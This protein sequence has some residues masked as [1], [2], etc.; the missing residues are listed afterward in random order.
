M[1][2]DQSTPL[3]MQ[4]QAIKSEYQDSLVLFQVG[5]FYELFYDDAK[6]AASFL[7]IA[8]TK[9][10]KSQGM[11]IPL[12]GV[13]LH[14]INH[15]ITKLVKGGFKVALC[16]Q[17]ESPKPGTV[18][19]R[20]VTRV[21]TPG[22]LT[23]EI[24]LDSKS[25]SYLCA[26][27]NSGFIMAEILTARLSI[28]SLD[29]NNERCIENELARFYPDEIILKQ[30]DSLANILKK[31]GYPVTELAMDFSFIVN[32]CTAWM[33]T[34][35]KNDDF[36]KIAHNNDIKIAFTYFYAYIKKTQ[37]KIL[38]MMVSV[39]WY[40]PEEFLEIDRMTQKNLELVLN[41]YDGTSKGT[42]FSVIDQS[43][44]AMGSR[45]I[46]QW[47][48]RPLM[49]QQAIEQRQSVIEL[50][51]NNVR[52]HHR[53]QELL[54]SIGDIERTVGRILLER[55][56]IHDFVVLKKTVCIVPELKVILQESSCFEYPLLVVINEHIQVSDSLTQLLSTAF[57]E[58]MTNASIIK[59]GFDHELDAMRSLLSHGGQE[60]LA[61]EKAEQE[62]TGI[63]SLKVRY[64]EIHGYYIETTKL[65]A[66]QVPLH[67]KPLQ[68][69][70]GK[71]RFTIPALE[72]LQ[73]N[74]ER[75][76]VQVSLREKELFEGIK[77]II[78]S[79]QRLLRRLVWGLSHLDA[80]SGLANAAHMFRF[81]KPT[82]SNNRL[83]AIEQGWHPV[84][85]QSNTNR[86]IP[87]DTMLSDNQS[88]LIITG[89]NMGG[90]S[91]YLRQVALIL[92][93][94]H[95]GSFVPAKKANVML[96]DRLFSRIGAGDNL[97]QGK[98]TFLVEME[99][100]ALICNQ[101]TDR[102]FVILDEVGRGTSTHDGM[103]IAQAV[104]EYLVTEKKPLTLF[105]THYHELTELS[106][107]YSSIASYYTASTYVNDSIVFLYQVVTG[108]AQGSFGLKVA[109]L[110][111]LPKEIVAR[112]EFLLSQS[113][114][115]RHIDIQAITTKPLSQTPVDH[116]KM[117]YK[118]LLDKIEHVLARVDYNTTTPRQALQ[119]I[120]HLSD[121]FQKE[122]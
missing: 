78:F 88:L 82:I 84:V 85:A 29:R 21:L 96:L 18:V 95:M 11:D 63:T 8:L 59:Q 62:T 17:L 92:I 108:V 105:A 36:E 100:T 44:T 16:D 74:I 61:L 56:T 113:D 53:V 99:E 58:D 2:H 60:I 71:E 14:T 26:I 57:N 110:A 91:T 97:A 90:K 23:E 115:S 64:N 101:A 120:W 40:Q 43:S 107:T 25:S 38:E 52:F 114:Q 22:T 19:K 46:K 73:H 72:L 35:L 30:D 98:S 81:V 112:A 76:K 6:V 79:H 37:S 69:L 121:L 48:L 5:D 27:S 4:Y 118:A 42:L 15:Y 31:N 86:F 83:I 103:A 13:P 9:R 94:A 33:R 87:N 1:S 12:C 117:A 66:A 51:I 93:L 24:L 55:A 116:E 70:V 3:M 65:G 47:L 28:T 68:S 122:H 102:S 34:S 77:K 89:P 41:N 45:L 111:Q 39:E 109:Q 106:K 10:G 32:E 7:G 119:L 75:A 20:G 54:Q 80:C 49:N 50:L 67:Y 104:I